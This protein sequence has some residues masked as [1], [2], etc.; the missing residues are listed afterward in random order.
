VP[1]KHKKLPMGY[2]ASSLAYKN[3]NNHHSALTTTTKKTLNEVKNQ[4]QF[5][6]LWNKW[7]GRTNCWLK[8]WRHEARIPAS[9]RR[10]PWAEA[11]AR[12]SLRIKQRNR[13]KKLNCNQLTDGGSVWTRLRVKKHQESPVI[14]RPQ[15]LVSST[16]QEPSLIVTMNIREKSPPWLLGVR[17]KTN[18]NSF[19]YTRLFCPQQVCPQKKLLFWGFMR[20]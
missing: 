14:G 4:Q 3:L 9:Q 11:F 15:P 13:Q 19:E 17:Q 1:S 12:I 2:L 8:N 18:S 16:F 7:G 6:Y 10:N 5:L 20:T